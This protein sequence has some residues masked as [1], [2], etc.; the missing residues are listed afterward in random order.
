MLFVDWW[1]HAA[2]WRSSHALIPD[3]GDEV[4]SAKVQATSL[5][6]RNLCMSKTRYAEMK[7]ERDWHKRRYVLCLK[8]NN[9]QEYNN[10]QPTLLKVTKSFYIVTVLGQL[11]FTL[12]TQIAQTWLSKGTVWIRPLYTRIWQ[13][14][15]WV[16]AWV[17]KLRRRAW[18]MMRF[19]RKT[20]IRESHVLLG[21]VRTDDYHTGRL[22]QLL[23]TTS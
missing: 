7:R 21:E 6:L 19:G 14:Y 3:V 13:K 2:G 10:Q 16:L 18:L 23:E 15:H 12:F 20:G 17:E 5:M 9:N 4:V 1:Q 22:G 11:P 8:N